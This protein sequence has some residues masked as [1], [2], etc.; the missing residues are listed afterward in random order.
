MTNLEADLANL[1]KGKSEQTK[2][3][4]MLEKQK[5]EL[6][7][8]L[9]DTQATLDRVNQENSALK[10]IEQEI[11]NLRK[12]PLENSTETENQ[13]ENEGQSV[14]AIISLCEAKQLEITEK[15]KQLEKIDKENKKLEKVN[16]ENKECIKKYETKQQ[17][18]ITDTEQLIKEKCSITKQSLILEENNRTLRSI[19]KY[20]ELED[21]ATKQSNTPAPERKDKAQ[22][23]TNSGD[24]SSHKKANKGDEKKER[25]HADNLIKTKPCWHFENRTCSYGEECRYQHRK[26]YQRIK[27]K[28]ENAEHTP[29]KRKAP[30]KNLRSTEPR[31]RKKSDERKERRDEY[32]WH[33]ENNRCRYGNQCKDKHRNRKRTEESKERYLRTNPKTTDPCW[34][35][36]N[37]ECIFGERCKN[38]HRIKENDNK[39]DEQPNQEEKQEIEEDQ[40]RT[41]EDEDEENH[42][43]TF[44]ENRVTQETENLY[45]EVLMSPWV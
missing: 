42:D 38:E 31:L 44:L 22:K 10:T 17:E 26:G 34:Y 35:F 40:E 2:K 28:E 45:K 39:F 14:N 18:L 21:I 29:E 5:T 4:K 37:T 25:E 30:S 6:Q 43:D 1:E 11:Q 19:V 9:A 15:V 32:C 36:E 27:N 8:N 20:L 33:D 24:P 3:I 12:E 16:K 13:N 23:Q 7:E 41:D